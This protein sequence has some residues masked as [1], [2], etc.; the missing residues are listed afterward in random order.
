MRTATPRD[1]VLA[2]L[3][4]EKNERVPCAPHILGINNLP[5][6]LL[7]EH[8]EGPLD[9][10]AISRFVGG[11]VFHEVKGATLRYGEG[12]AA[13]SWWE[14]ER[15]LT[16]LET[17]AGRLCAVKMRKEI[18]TFAYDPTPGLCL[19]PPQVTETE[20]EYF[21][22]DLDDYAALQAYHEGL[23]YVSEAEAVAEAVQQVGADGVVVVSAGASPLYGLVSHFAGLERTIYDLFDD[24]E[25]VEAAMAAMERSNLRLIRAL[26]D[27]PADIIRITEDLDTSLVS[28]ALFAQYALPS[29]KAYAALCHAHGK[30]MVIHM[31]GR[32]RA[33]LPLLR[34]SGADGI[35]CLC[36]P[37]TGDTP[38][39]YAHEVLGD[40]VAILARVDPPLLLDGTPDA[41]EAAVAGMIRQAEGRLMILLPC[42]RARLDNLRAVIRAAEAWRPQ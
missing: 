10:L 27:T 30:L 38:I 4:R 5:G 6:Q 22:K 42:G 18:P 11:S 1:H 29:L 31:C 16:A 33:F 23:D 2:V 17:P 39:A 9:R 3:R 28:P 24:P 13:S 41:L 14:G 8:L 40:K 21:V 19:P 37:E 25:R 20:T 32:I 26:C 34:E 12:I 15:H 35:H 7:P 36:P